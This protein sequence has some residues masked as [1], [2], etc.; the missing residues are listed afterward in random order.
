MNRFCQN[1][2]YFIRKEEKRHAVL[3]GI[4]FSGG[5]EWIRVAHSLILPF[6]DF[7]DGCRNFASYFLQAY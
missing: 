6:L 7:G 1:N 5:G 3:L 2:M 4:T